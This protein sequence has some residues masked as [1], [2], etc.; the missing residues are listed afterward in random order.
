MIDIIIP[1]YNAHKTIRNTLL[2]IC[3]QTLKDK[4]SVYIIDDC[5]NK[6]YNEEVEMFKDKIKIKE[7]KTKKNS[8]P[9]VAR[10]LGLDN[11]D[12][13]YVIFMDSDDVFFDCFSVENLYNNI[14][15][16]DFDIAIGYVTVESKDGN[17]ND[18][19]KEGSLHGKM[20][21]RKIINKYN[22][23]FND[24]S[25]HEDLSFYLLYLLA[26]NKIKYVENNIYVYRFNS[27]SIT[28]TNSFDY[29]YRTFKIY[30]KN[31]EWLVYSAEIRHFDKLEI[32]KDVFYACV[33]AYCRYLENFYTANADNVLKNSIPLYKLYKKYENL[34]DYNDKFELYSAITFN[35]IPQISLDDFLNLVKNKI[36]CN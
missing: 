20:F 18:D 8:G 14:H 6:N 19:I 33:I 21:L 3:M 35:F 34:L 4:I 36:N 28:Q 7:I 24:T 26:S 12:G 11:S 1:A 9:G 13:D 32:A 16:T 23:R 30:V 31:M 17:L 25:N 5:S 2:S 27:N 29:Q 10:Q 15:N 22:L